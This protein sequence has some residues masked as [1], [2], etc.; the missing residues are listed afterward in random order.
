MPKENNKMQ[1]DI[2]N[3]I[4]QNVNDLL[5]IKEIYKR[6]EELR[7]KT[8]QIKSID[9][10]LVKKL[11]K[12]YES[13]KKIILDENI[14][15]ELNNK[16]ESK[17]NITDVFNNSFLTET[18]FT[19]DKDKIILKKN[20]YSVSIKDYR[21]GYIQKLNSV[22]GNN[23][24]LIVNSGSGTFIK[25]HAIY[26]DIKTTYS[27]NIIFGVNFVEV[28]DTSHF[29]IGDNVL[30]RLGDNPYD[31]IETKKSLHAKITNIEDNKIYLSVNI[32]V[33]LD[34][35]SVT[36][37][38]NKTIYKLYANNN[39][40]SYKN[41]KLIAADKTNMESGIDLRYLK[42]I[43]IENI[44]SQNC[45]AGTVMMAYCQNVDISNIRCLKCNAPNTQG[46]KGRTFNFW[47]CENVT[48]NN[49]ESSAN[50]GCVIFVESYC[51][52]IIFNNLIIH[53]FRSDKLGKELI[54]MVQ[55][56]ECE[57]NNLT[58][59]S[60][61]QFILTANGGSTNEYTINNLTI[62][63]DK[64]FKGGL[65]T[66]RIRG[67]FKHTINNISYTMNFNDKRK[68][69]IELDLK[70][71]LYKILDF[72]NILITSYR[73]DLIN[74]DFNSING[75]FYRKGASNGL[76]LKPTDL[77][78]TY[79]ECDKNGLGLG[80]DYNTDYTKTQGFLISC[81]GITGITDTGKKIRIVYDYVNI[82]TD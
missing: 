21:N 32:P 6:I 58:I 35:T 43:T 63:S 27:S 39:N 20:N 4:K 12:E 16:I 23:S 22:D 49:V 80:S 62:N 13:L 51:K 10:T 40:K 7:E 45:G 65:H 54:M 15:I 74:C 30:L 2:E 24:S 52:N 19:T 5:S 53:D 68:G 55:G 82:I 41:L 44:E 81:G 67:V 79:L 77:T 64:M 42:D 9:N 73:V 8:S 33:N 70:D 75:I 47:N 18:N 37:E 11:K 3:L 31:K 78:L 50:Q 48:V 38:N 26:S 57:F 72:Q 14:Q 59:N 60:N 61:N 17:A 46:S 76:N 34:L 71:G 29:S 25:A 56:S 1:V 28:L 69:I 66:G 36:N